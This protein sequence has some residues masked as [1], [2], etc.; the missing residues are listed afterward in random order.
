[1]N[2]NQKVFDMFYTGTNRAA[3]GRRSLGLGLG[4]CRSII[5]AHGEKYGYQTISP[6]GLYL[7]TLPAEEV[8][9]HE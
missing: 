4:L 2:R 9:L 7:L 8:T 6:R 3:D 5:R 1:M